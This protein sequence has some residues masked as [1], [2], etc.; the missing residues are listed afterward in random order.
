VVPFARLLRVQ[1]RVAVVH[2]VIW[3][4]AEA[5]SKAVAV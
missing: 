1:V 5:A 4:P 3:L 2:V